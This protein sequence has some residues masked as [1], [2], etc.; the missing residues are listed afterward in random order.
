MSG[1]LI[2]KNNGKFKQSKNHIT[3]QFIEILGKQCGYCENGKN[4]EHTENH[5]RNRL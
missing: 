2:F 1:Y 3:L 5:S 4:Y